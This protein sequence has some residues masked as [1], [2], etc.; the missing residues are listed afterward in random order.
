[1]SV[2]ISLIIV[3]GGPAGLFCALQAASE[4]IDVLVLEKKRSCGNKLLISGSGQCNITHDGEIQQFLLHYGDNGSF[5]KPSLMNFGNQDLISF[6]NE[7]GVPLEIEPGGKVFPISHKA[8]DILDFLIHDCQKYGVRIKNSSPVTDVTYT[9][10][11]FQV[12]TD[13]DIVTSNYL[14]IA[15]GGET[16]PATG[17]TG[18][19]FTFASRLGHTVTETGSALTGIQV[20]DYRFSDL[21][22]ISFADLNITLFRDGKKI[23]THIGDILFTHSGL[24]GP[25]ILDFS[26]YIRP[27]DTLKVSFTPGIDTREMNEKL[28]KRI[29]E[30]GSKQLRTVLNGFRLPERVVR[31][32][33]ELANV[34]P[35]LTGPHLTKKDRTNLVDLITACPFEVSK[36]GGHEEAMATR[37]GVN[38]SEVNPKTMESRIISG[39]FFVG[40]V[41]DIDGDTGGYNLQAAFSTAK[42]AGQRIHVLSEDE[43]H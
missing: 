31:R 11:R 17:S 40:E 25:G 9:D 8:S 14:V 23:K 18:D 1:M 27:G 35:D 19:G 7:R 41:L 15:T 43:K 42:L 38:L 12:T 5:L 37:G 2:D 24:S 13:E 34:D 22:G 29:S 3:G 10:G 6:F 36:L 4:N 20:K 30:S 28:I 33:L 32:L 21:S 26:R 16:Y 39:L